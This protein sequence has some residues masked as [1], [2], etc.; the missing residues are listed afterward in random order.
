MTPE[1]WAPALRELFK[2]AR[3]GLSAYQD[4]LVLVGGLAKFFYLNHPDFRAPEVT[5]RATV[6]LDIALDQHARSRSE[7]IHTRLVQAGLIPYVVLD[8]QGHPLEQQYQLVE[9]GSAIRAETG[10]ELLVARQGFPRRPRRLS[11]IVPSELRHV[12]LL[13]HHPIP[14]DVGQTGIVRLPHPLA[15]VAQKTL[16]R[17]YRDPRKAI[18]DQADV[19]F[20]VWGFQP[21]WPGWQEQFQ[22]FKAGRTFRRRLHDVR[23]ILTDLYRDEYTTG[24]QAVAQLYL[25]LGGPS[26]DP[27]LVSR[28]MRDFLAQLPDL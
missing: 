3:T 15:Y 27:A 6:D 17:P 13:L 20:T 21:P 14:I 2:R 4:H 25:N 1:T 5:P 24:S 19:F 22:H 26:P 18:S 11:G 8:A 10:L 16:I 9:E 12:D 28:I 23:I 7:D